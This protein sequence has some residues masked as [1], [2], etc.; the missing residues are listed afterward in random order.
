[1]SP[2]VGLQRRRRPTARRSWTQRAWRCAA[3]IWRYCYRSIHEEYSFITHT[4]INTVGGRDTSG[5]TGNRRTVPPPCARSCVISCSNTIALR[6][7][8]HRS[9][10]WDFWTNLSTLQPCCATGS[11]VKLAVPRCVRGYNASFAVERHCPCC[12]S[13]CSCCQQQRCQIDLK[14]LLPCITCA[15]MA[16]PSAPA[17]TCT[18]YMQR[19][20][21]GAALP[22][23]GTP[24][25]A[26]PGG[27]HV[28]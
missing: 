13:T 20:W 21:R 1:M 18:A 3:D 11:P 7:I 8:A 2:W 10:C 5:C 28:C 23:A 17:N 22:A 14:P 24:H 15:G 9:I 4:A 6:C 19:D 27:G 25:A 26:P 12:C 16:G